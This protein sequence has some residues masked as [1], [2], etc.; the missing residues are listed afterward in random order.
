MYVFFAA[1]ALLLVT[2][3]LSLTIKPA[4]VIEKALHK[5]TKRITNNQRVGFLITCIGVL[6]FVAA[7]LAR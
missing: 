6:T 4:G 5:G 3:G 2:L 7:L 1:T